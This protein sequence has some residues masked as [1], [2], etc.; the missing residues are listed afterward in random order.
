MHAGDSKTWVQSLGRKDP[1]EKK[2]ETHSS[3]LAWQIPWIEKPVGYRP[4]GCKESDTTE[5]TMNRKTVIR[6]VDWGRVLELLNY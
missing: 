3:I 6:Q 4:W 5:Y 1:L 2:L